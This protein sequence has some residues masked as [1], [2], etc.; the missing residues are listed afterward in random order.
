MYGDQ[1]Y[2]KQDKKQIALFAYHLSFK[3]PTKDEIMDFKLIPQDG[4]WSE[5]HYEA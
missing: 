3:H 1:L 4:I 2:G 5:F